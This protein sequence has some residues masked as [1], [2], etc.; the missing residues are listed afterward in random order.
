MRLLVARQYAFT[1]SRV[2]QQSASQLCTVSAQLGPLHM[3]CP[4]RPAR[5]PTWRGCHAAGLCAM[6]R[7]VQT[8]RRCRRVP[9]RRHMPGSGGSSSADSISV[10]GTAEEGGCYSRRQLHANSSGSGSGR[11]VTVIIIAHHSLSARS[12]CSSSGWTHSSSCGGYG[13]R[14]EWFYS[15]TAVGSEQVVLKPAPP[16]AARVWR[17]QAAATALGSAHLRPFL[18]NVTVARWPSTFIAT[19]CPAAAGSSCS[20]TTPAPSAGGT[21][22]A[23]AAMTRAGMLAVPPV[24]EPRELRRGGGA[25]G[26]SH[27]QGRLG[28]RAAAA[29]GAGRRRRRV[30]GCAAGARIWGPLTAA[31]RPQLHGQPRT[32]RPSSNPSCL[33]L[34]LL[35]PGGVQPAQNA[36]AVAST[37]VGARTAGRCSPP[38]RARGL[39]PERAPGR[40]GWGPPRAAVGEAF[41]RAKSRRV[42]R[43]R[44]SRPLP[45]LAPRSLRT[46]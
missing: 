1:G 28:S 40:P 39:L 44:C 27:L 5:H 18:L 24:S 25:G 34:T 29:C 41:L 6:R 16:Q 36:C 26:S 17:Q 45:P 43:P 46:S 30:G 20:R 22:A 19:P 2:A 14:S 31:A 15:S 8:T 4:A 38:G 42:G 23:A 35:L 32:R 33:P 21:T 13:R 10:K 7:N 3:G 9:G 12:E 37:P 11:R